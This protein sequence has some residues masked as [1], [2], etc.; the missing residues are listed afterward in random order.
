[1][2]AKNTGPL[3]KLI[4]DRARTVLGI[5]APAG[6]SEILRGGAQTQQW[7]GPMVIPSSHPLWTPASAC[8]HSLLSSPGAVFVSQDPQSQGECVCVLLNG[9][10][11]EPQSE[12]V[13]GLN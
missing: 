5:H 6:F 8:G 2:P 1:M 11:A 9:V 7:T 12:C 13:P 4:L 10:G 3:A